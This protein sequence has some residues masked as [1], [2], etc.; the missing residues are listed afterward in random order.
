MDLKEV[1]QFFEDKKEDKDVQTFIGELNPVNLDRAKGFFEKDEDAKRWMTS[2]RDST[3]TKALETYKEKT[4]PGLIKDSNDKLRLEL[5]PQETDSDIMIR[6]LKESQEKLVGELKAKDLLGYAEKEMT[7]QKLPVGLAK[8]FI[9]ADD[10]L[11]KTNIDLL[12]ELNSEAIKAQVEDIFK[13]H[14]G[15]PTKAPDLGGDFYTREQ[16]EKMPEADMIKNWPKVEKSLKQI[17]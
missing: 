10:T 13:E 14:G 17:G 12:G 1:K 16:M 2:Q 8:F 6:E 9:G 7:T 11:T 4:V 15:V 5:S 3:V